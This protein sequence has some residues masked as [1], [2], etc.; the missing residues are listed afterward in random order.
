MLKNVYFFNFDSSALFCDFFRFWLDF[1]RPGAVKKS[2]KI[3]KNCTKIDFGMDSV[4]KEASG[5]VLGGFWE[6]FGI[7][8]EKIWE[9]FCSFWDGLGEANND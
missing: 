7:V 1:G 8:L 6:S 2:K 4:L 5:R 3:E 9:D